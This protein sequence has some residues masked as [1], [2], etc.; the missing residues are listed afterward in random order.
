VF[1]RELGSFWR[2]DEPDELCRCAPE[3]RVWQM[4]ISNGLPSLRCTTCARE[5]P[6]MHGDW[7]EYLTM[8]PVRVHAE[9]KGD[10]IPRC[11]CNKQ[12]V[13]W[14]EGNAWLEVTLEREE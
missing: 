4:E 6:F 2:D 13:L 3:P 11:T 7:L 10:C 14:C 8:A 12:V 9:W 5:A 1:D